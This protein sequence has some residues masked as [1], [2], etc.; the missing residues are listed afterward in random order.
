MTPRSNRRRF[1]SSAG[2]TAAGIGMFGIL[3]SRSARGA[4]A[5]RSAL[6]TPVLG[7]IGCGGMGR[8]NA[9]TFI[10]QKVP[11]ACVCDV[12]SRHAGEAADEFEKKQGK[13][14]DIV[15]DFR[16]LLDRKDIDA[17]IIATPDHWHALPTV[18]AAEAGKDM[19]LEKPIS[20]DIH[21]AKTMA[22]ACAKHNRVVQV[23][24][25]QRSTREFVAALDYVR[26]GKLG[27]VV[28]A[29]AWKTDTA[30]LG[31]NAPASPPAELDYDF[32]VGP[33]ELVPY[34]E[35]NCHYN[36]RWF[37]NTAAGMTGDWGVHMIDI[38]LLGLGK[39][40]DDVAL[41]EEVACQGGKLAYPDDDRTTPDTQ[42]ALLKYPGAVLQWETNRRPLDGEHD[43][44]TQFIADNGNTVT[45]W[46][47]DWSIKS[48]DNKDIEKPEGPEG[49]DG[50]GSHIAD[51][52]QCVESRKASRSNIASMAK[53][54]IVCHLI[55][56]SYLAK[57][58]V[59]FDAGKLDIDGDTGRGTQSYRSDYR[60]PWVLPS[61]F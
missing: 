39:G 18:L 4:V 36:W 1:F 31:K 42:L 51:F 2:A 60:S 47:G 14:P 23:G 3:G 29:R 46:R 49:M 35:R 45:V 54:T 5:P 40:G 50:L 33:A 25:W 52:L 15:K 38:A 20:H 34:T 6:K 24:T 56:A 59:R 13:R 10:D 30:Q 17:V 44:G 8:A 28:V 41:P 37:W 19:Y 16:Q 26:S 27:R 7:L 57:V 12:D 43:N 61:Y 48:P 58:P 21:E 11:V 32:W 55:N 53:T 9:N 22:A